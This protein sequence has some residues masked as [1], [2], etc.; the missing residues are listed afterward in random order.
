M[1]EIDAKEKLI[2]H[3]TGPCIIADNSAGVNKVSPGI[4]EDIFSFL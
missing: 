4:K 3:H 1:A 2:K